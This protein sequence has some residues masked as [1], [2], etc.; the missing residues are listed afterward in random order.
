MKRKRKLVKIR[1]TIFDICIPIFLILFVYLCIL[2]I[3]ATIGY[4]FSSR[5]Q[6]IFMGLVVVVITFRFFFTLI[7]ELQNWT[8]KKINKTLQKQ[9]KI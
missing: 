4:T 3:Y 8:R 7:K 2:V 5:G 1:R 6:L 9:K